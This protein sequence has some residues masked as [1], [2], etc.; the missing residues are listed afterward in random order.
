MFEYDHL[1]P[2]DVVQKGA[3]HEA[4][5]VVHE[6][7]FASPLGGQVP[8]YLV[9]PEAMAGSCAGLIYLHPGQGDRSTFLPEAVAMA[10][11]GAVSLLIDAPY[12]RPGRARL[13]GDYQMKAE[14][15][16]TLYR[17]IVLDLRRCVDL[18]SVRPDV[19]PGRIGYVGHSL[20]ATWGGPL[21]GSE[22]RIRAAVLMAGYA[23]LTDWYRH[24]GHLLAR[25][26]R[27]RFPSP[28]HMESYLAVLARLDPE[29]HAGQ[30]AG[31]MLFQ[32]AREDDF[33]D[34][35]QAERYLAAAPADH[36]VRWYAA[37]HLFTGCPEARLDRARWLAE[38]LGLGLLPA[39]VE[40]RL[41]AIGG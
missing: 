3:A 16:A 37:D 40:K 23:S 36:A 4:G 15:E 1:A 39:A 38:G 32:Y 30:A 20:G 35:V 6:I 27:E 5:A 33:V 24:S 7:T 29:R 11:A 10:G 22:R 19:D 13:T 9:V 14:E 12:L 26:F 31:A 17:Q 18:L 41:E 2:L 28:A 21:A 25:R 8:A 34:S